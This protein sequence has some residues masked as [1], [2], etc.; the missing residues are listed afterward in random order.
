MNKKIVT[1]DIL[2]QMLFPE[3]INVSLFTHFLIQPNTFFRFKPL[4]QQF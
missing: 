1:A 2:M 4:L 3:K